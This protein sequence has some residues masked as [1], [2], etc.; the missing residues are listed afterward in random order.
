MDRV[1]QALLPEIAEL[2]NCT[3]ITCHSLVIKVII[4]EV[5]DGIHSRCCE[6]DERDGP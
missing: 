4:K 3:T 5:A 2:T 1:T 6:E